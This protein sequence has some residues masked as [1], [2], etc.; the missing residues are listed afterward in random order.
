MPHNHPLVN[1][2]ITLLEDAKATEIIAINVQQQTDITDYMIIA[3]G[4]SNRHLSAISEHVIVATKAIG[5]K[6]IGVEG[7]Q[8]NEWILVD[9]GDVIVHI[10]HPETRAY[11]QLE[12]LWSEQL[13][14][15]H[16]VLSPAS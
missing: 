6:P 12:K 1:Q 14:K 11:Y 13:P 4:R 10:M 9:L 8:D 3:N 15:P 7:Q 5:L 16:S 2:L